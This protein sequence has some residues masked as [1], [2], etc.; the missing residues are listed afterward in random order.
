MA[1]RIHLMN[2]G[3]VSWSSR[4]MQ[5]VALS[6]TEAEYMAMT[7]AAKDVVHLRQLIGDL[8]GRPKGPTVLWCDNQAAML[9]SKTA[10]FRNR[11]KHIAV[12]FHYIRQ[13]EERL[14]IRTKFIRTDEQPADMLTKNLC[15]PKLEFSRLK[16]G[17]RSESEV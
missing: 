5:T 7:E 11:T 9:L 17:M 10:Q 1:G 4:L 15:G 8:V 13:Q 12:R 3:P 6:T 14:V 2:G 16:V